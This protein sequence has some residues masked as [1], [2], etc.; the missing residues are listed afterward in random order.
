M[1][2]PRGRGTA[3]RAVREAALGRPL[4]EE[5]DGAGAHVRRLPR[6]EHV[7]AAQD[8]RALRRLRRL[9]RGSWP[10]RLGVGPPCAPGGSG[11]LLR[12]A[13]RRRLGA[14]DRRSDSARVRAPRGRGGRAVAQTPPR[15]SRRPLH[16]PGPPARERHSPIRW[17]AW[18]R[19]R[20]VATELAARWRRCS[21]GWSCCG[22]ARLG[23][24]CS[25]APAV[26]HTRR[27][28]IASGCPVEGSP[29]KP[30]AVELASRSQSRRARRSAGG[31][32][33]QRSARRAVD[34]C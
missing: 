25:S 26:R 18:L 8:L 4:R 15:R 11:G 1:R 23:S 3:G 34:A 13:R 12:A 28:A 7:G 17:R 21:T 2:S 14:L 30:L 33:H 20:S 24:A 32:H 29:T 5:A 31:A 19:S 22:R 10:R 6:H 9:L 16:C 27:G